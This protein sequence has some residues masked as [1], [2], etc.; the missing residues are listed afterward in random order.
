MEGIIHG[1][2]KGLNAAQTRQAWGAFFEAM[3]PKSACRVFILPWALPPKS[4]P[5]TENSFSKRAEAFWDVPFR[6][7]VIESAE[8]FNNR[9]AQ[10]AATEPVLVYLPGGILGGNM[11]EEAGKIKLPDATD[12]ITFAGISAGAYALM[13]TYYNP[14]KKQIL[15]GGGLFRGGVCCHGDAK[16]KEALEKLPTEKHRPFYFLPDGVLKVL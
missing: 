4:W 10:F 7:S 15:T 5:Q 3:Q 8:D 2:F 6:A 14:R 9:L 11:V 12:H 13:D 1:G 16:R